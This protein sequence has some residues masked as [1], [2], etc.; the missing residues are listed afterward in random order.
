MYKNL[1]SCVR[2]DD[3]VT[4]WFTI[5]RGIRQGDSLAPLLFAIF[6]NDLAI[7]INNLNL[8]YRDWNR[9]KD[10]YSHVR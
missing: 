10:Q 2:I 3:M 5:D 8:R 4:D 9:R 6:V 7:D 1:Q